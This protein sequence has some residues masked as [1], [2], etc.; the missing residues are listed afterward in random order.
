[1]LE[2]LLR[3]WVEDVGLPSKS[4]LTMPMTSMGVICNPEPKLNI[5]VTRIHFSIDTKIP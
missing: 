3:G 1:M 4:F 5:S 2:A